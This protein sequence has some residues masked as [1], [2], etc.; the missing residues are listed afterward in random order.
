[1]NSLVRWFFLVL[2]VRFFFWIFFFF[3]GGGGGGCSARYIGKKDD[4]GYVGLHL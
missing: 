3:L 4:C 2:F 1:M